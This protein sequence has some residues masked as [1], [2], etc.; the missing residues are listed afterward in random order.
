MRH[1]NVLGSNLC[2]KK[3][4]KSAINTPNYHL[5]IEE[6]HC[7]LDPLKEESRIDYASE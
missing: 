6:S 4:S 7:Y 2:D 5:R 1:S 3:I